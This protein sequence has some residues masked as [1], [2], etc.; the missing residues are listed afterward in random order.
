MGEALLFGN[1][2]Q[3]LLKR[4]PQEGETLIAS[5]ASIA[6]AFAD[7]LQVPKA[8]VPIGTAVPTPMRRQS[9]TGVLADSPRLIENSLRDRALLELGHADRSLDAALNDLVDELAA[10]VA[11]ASERTARERLYASLA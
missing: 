2:T 5:G 6:A 10:A 9:V 4:P 7:P 11:T 3:R 8:Y 1:F